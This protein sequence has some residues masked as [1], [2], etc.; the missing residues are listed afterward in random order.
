[1]LILPFLLFKGTLRHYKKVFVPVFLSV[2]F[3]YRFVFNK[4]TT[5]I[6]VDLF[7]F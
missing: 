5:F 6:N 2:H 7:S 1:M 4:L 3:G